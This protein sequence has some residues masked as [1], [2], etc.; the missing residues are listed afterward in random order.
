LLSS[1]KIKKSKNIEELEPFR[2]IG[3]NCQYMTNLSKDSK[4]GKKTSQNNSKL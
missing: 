4:S 2:K 3:I 1:N